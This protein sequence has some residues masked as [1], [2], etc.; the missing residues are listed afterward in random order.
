MVGAVVVRIDMDETFR[1]GSVLGEAELIVLVEMLDE[2]VPGSG[3]GAAD[4]LD[5]RLV[6]GRL[7]LEEV[8]AALG[9]PESSSA[10]IRAWSEA[11]PGS[12]GARWFEILRAWAWESYLCDPVWGGNRDEQGWRRFGYG[13]RPKTGRGDGSR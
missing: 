7:E 5:R 2:L 10:R 3:A 12:A 13:G 4:Y 11:E 8:R 1:L 6:A 9:G